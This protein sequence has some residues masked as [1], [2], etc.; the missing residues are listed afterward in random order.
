MATL[1]FDTHAF[2][3]KLTTAG[4]PEAQAEILAQEQANLIENRLATKVDITTLEKNIEMKFEAKI[5][6]V[7]SDIIK[8]VAGLLIAQAALVAA[9]LKLFTGA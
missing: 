5:E 8:W 4:M 7:K 2:V 6:S 3:K 1:V 9:L